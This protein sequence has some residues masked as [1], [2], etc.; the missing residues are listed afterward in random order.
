[1]QT[2][3]IFSVSSLTRQIKELLETAFPPLWVEGEVSNFKPHYSGH[4]YFTLKDSEAQISCVMWRSR[5]EKNTLTLQDGLK[6]RVYGLVRVY[7]RGGRYQL[8]A[9]KIEE[10]GIGDL[11]IR[12]EALKQRLFEEGLFDEK[13]KKNI[14]KYPSRIGVITSQTG[15]AVRDILSVLKRRCPSVEIIFR[16]VKV[17]GEGS[18]QEI[19]S[20]IQLFNQYGQVD[21]LIVGRGGGSLEDIWAFNEEVVARAI[22]NSKIPII[23]AV[24]HE[25]D[26]TIADMVSDLRAPTPSAAAE[27]AAPADADLIDFISDFRRSMQRNIAE[28]IRRYKKDI[29]LIKNSYAF[30]RT[31]DIIR[32]FSMRIDEITQRLVLLG[33]NR[34]NQLITYTTNLERRFVA[35]NPAQVLNRGYALIYK[36][37][38]VVASVAAVAV[39]DRIKV[40]LKD[41]KLDSIIK[42]VAHE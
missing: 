2:D 35:L 11:Q 6:I 21:L 15:A 33:R 10:A 3:Q 27:L 29:Q 5:A 17:Q 20:A 39:G 22:F 26:F 8:D 32:Q 37:N 9:Y 38:K 36:K 25:I 31:D 41:G 14:P 1:M 24:G 40:H 4:L 16:S 34:L 30:G 42:G 18:A 19:A 7:E 23:S 12:F 13:Y 28:K